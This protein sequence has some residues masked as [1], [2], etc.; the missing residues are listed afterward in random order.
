MPPPPLA[1]PPP[2]GGD[3]PPET[4]SDRLLLVYM[5]RSSRERVEQTSTFERAL[6]RQGR[7]F[8]DAIA[9]L[10]SDFRIFGALML[11][12]VLALS[13]VNVAIESGALS[14]TRA[15]AGD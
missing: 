14:F 9:L 13:G 6:S 10:R 1:F 2:P 4:R 5:E 15:P 11:L 12:G 8:R 7:D 3:R